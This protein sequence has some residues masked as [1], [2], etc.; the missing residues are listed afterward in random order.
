MRSLHLK[1]F[2]SRDLL[3][4]IMIKQH[5]QI[6]KQIECHPLSRQHFSHKLYI[7]EQTAP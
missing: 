5:S 4:Q 1:T 6:Y 2:V 3:I 7:F